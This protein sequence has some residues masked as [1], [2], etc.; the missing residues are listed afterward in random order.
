MGAAEAWAQEH[1][2]N[3]VVLYTRI[4]RD[5]ARTFYERIGYTRAATAHLMSE[6]LHAV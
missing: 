1:G 3:Y 2:L 5:E 4:D 6:P